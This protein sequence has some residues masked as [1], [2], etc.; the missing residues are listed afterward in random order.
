MRHDVKM[1]GRFWVSGFVLLVLCGAH[2]CAIQVSAPGSAQEGASQG[3]SADSDSHANDGG[4]GGSSEPIVNMPFPVGTEWLCTQ[5][6]NGSYSHTYN[7]T[8][9]DVD[10]DTPN[11]PASLANLYAPT[12]GTAY[13]YY[14][15]SGFGYHVNIDRGD[16]TYVVLGHLAEFAGGLTSGAYVAAGTYLG[17]AGCTGNC[18]GEHVHLGVHSGN[19][20][21]DANV[22]TSIP[23]RVFAADTAFNDGAEPILTD[24]MVCG[25][26]GGHWYESQL[27]VAQNDS[28]NDAQDSA[29]DNEPCDDDDHDDNGDDDSQ[30]S[31]PSDDDDDASDDGPQTDD[32]SQDDDD[33]SDEGESWRDVCWV[34]SGLSNPHDGELWL[35][36]GSWDTL[37]D[38]S[39]PFSSI[40]GLV[41][42]SSGAT[43]VLNG[44]FTADG[45]PSPWWICANTGSSLYV[46]GFFHVDGEQASVWPLSNGANGCDVAL[47]VP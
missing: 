13:V 28:P 16:G 30:D 2:G 29:N 22:G 21:S 1:L 39:G 20:S 34:P 35:W 44:E 17:K 27:S 7:S 4:F 6:A 5:G 14:N 40:C 31:P 19:A 45:L 26:S 32:D 41:Y 3:G 25:L 24:T 46:Y 18:T 47:E 43:I 12:T 33:T 15:A 9:H 8:R 36:T 10:F 37:T 42:T 23:F 38:Y 11:P